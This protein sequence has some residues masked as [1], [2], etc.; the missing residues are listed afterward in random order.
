MRQVEDL[1]QLEW[2][3]DIKMSEVEKHNTVE[4]LWIVYKGFVYDVTLYVSRHPGGVQCLVKPQ[5]GPDI[6]DMFKRIHGGLDME[7]WAK[8]KIGKLVPE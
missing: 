8:L 7:V 3:G 2:R 5:T 6:T 1:P 4:D